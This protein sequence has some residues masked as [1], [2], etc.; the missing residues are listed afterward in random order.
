MKA[1]NTSKERHIEW[2][3]G[4]NPNAI[5]AQ[6]AKGQKELIESAQLPIKGNSYSKL[7]VIEQYHKMGIKTFT[8]S[9]GDD[10]FVGV[11]LPAGWR[12]EATEH[13]MWNNLIDDKGRIR[14]SF[15]YKA[16]FYDRDAFINFNQRFT[17][18]TDFSDNESISY[19]VK[20]ANDN[21]VPFH[22]DKMTKDYKNPDYFKMQDKLTNECT[23]WLYEHY[24]EWEDINSYW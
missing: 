23:K 19:M 9:K 17:Y 14:A 20:D 18:V 22:T 16:A 3:F 21:S 10:L 8:K 24:P 15:F 5:E 7:N 2:L 1:T 11:K 6:E 12:K 13:S 4:G